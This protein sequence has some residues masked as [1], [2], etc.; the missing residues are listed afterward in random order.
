MI[1]FED[2]AAN[3]A[4][5]EHSSIEEQLSWLFALFDIDGN[6]QIDKFELLEIVRVCGTSADS[7]FD[8]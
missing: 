6:K 1:R 3:L 5:V 2:F 7:T 4:I 8:Y